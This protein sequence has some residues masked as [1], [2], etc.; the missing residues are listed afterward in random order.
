MEPFMGS[1][2]RLFTSKQ[3]S[4]LRVVNI[5]MDVWDSHAQSKC[6]GTIFSIL[7]TLFTLRLPLNIEY[8]DTG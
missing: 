6:P 7:T 1:S 4:F 2:H 3:V 8:F 5:I